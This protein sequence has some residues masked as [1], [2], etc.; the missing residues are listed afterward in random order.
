[1]EQRVDTGVQERAAINVHHTI[2][3][4]LVKADARPR[5]ADYLELRSRSILPRGARINRRCHGEAF[6]LANADQEFLED[7]TF[8]AELGRVRHVLPLAPA[9]GTEMPAGRDGAI[10]R[11][12]QDPNGR[13]AREVMPGLIHPHFH[14]ITRHRAGHED[15]PAV[16]QPAETVPLKDQPLNL[17]GHVPTRRERRRTLV[18]RRTLLAQRHI[19][20]FR[21]LLAQKTEKVTA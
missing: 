8:P 6:Q 4:S 3:F 9:A 19:H 5:P 17:H 16:G 14:L 21:V 12:R 13:A 1:M 11:R 2:R 10:G 15:H 7:T 18:N 20:H